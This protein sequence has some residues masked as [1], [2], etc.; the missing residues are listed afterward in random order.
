MAK[1]K[2]KKI[3]RDHKGEF[4]FETYF[5]RGKQ[6]RRKIYAVDGIPADEFYERNADPI[7][8][9]QDEEYEMLEAA[10]R[11]P[12]WRSTLE[13]DD[14]ETRSAKGL[15]DVLRELREMIAAE[16]GEGGVDG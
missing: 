13:R 5:I 1:A 9:L 16:L 11:S 4:V 10:C 12:M 8:L 2:K 7:T 14:A 3:R 15:G 6:K